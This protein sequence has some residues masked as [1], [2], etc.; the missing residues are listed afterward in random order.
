MELWLFIF[1]F[2]D[3]N[4][5]PWQGCM[6]ALPGSHAAAAEAASKTAALQ[7]P[8]ESVAGQVNIQERQMTLMHLA[9]VQH[10]GGHRRR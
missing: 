4:Y 5:A 3:S 6:P 9:Q 2:F 7:L 8:E 1:E 10:G